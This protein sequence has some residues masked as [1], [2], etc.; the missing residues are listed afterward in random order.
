ML[1][2]HP[3][4]LGLVEPQLQ[5]TVPVLNQSLVWLFPISCTVILRAMLESAQVEHL[6]LAA[7]AVHTVKLKRC[8]A[9]SLLPEFPAAI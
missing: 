8:Q 7:L 1:F 4:F 3:Q 2:Q 9:S 5:V 6:V